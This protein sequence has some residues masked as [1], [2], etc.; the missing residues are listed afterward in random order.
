MFRFLE[1]AF[2]MFLLALVVIAIV[3]GYS[4]SASFKVFIDDVLLEFTRVFKEKIHI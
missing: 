4:E 1:F 3:W 2:W